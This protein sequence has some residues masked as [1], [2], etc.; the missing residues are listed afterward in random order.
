MRGHMDAAEYNYVVL[1]FTLI[2]YISDAFEE[3]HDTIAANLVLVGY[4]LFGGNHD[5]RSD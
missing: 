4:P 3:R 1:G 2:K 5:D